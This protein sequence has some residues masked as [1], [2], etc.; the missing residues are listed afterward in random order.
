MYTPLPQKLIQARVQCSGLSNILFLS[1]ACVDQTGRPS[2][3]QAEQQYCNVLLHVQGPG[4]CNFQP[5]RLSHALEQ[6]LVAMYEHLLEWSIRGKE[7]PACHTFSDCT[8]SAVGRLLFRDC[9]S[10]NWLRLFWCVDDVQVSW[11]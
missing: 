3:L 1:C 4:A 5:K 8:S 6:S 9:L 2:G 7:E 10:L 11:S